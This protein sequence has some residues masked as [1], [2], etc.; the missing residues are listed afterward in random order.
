LPQLVTAIDPRVPFFNVGLLE[1]HTR[2]ATFQ[3]QLAANLLVVFGALALMLAAVGS[4]GVLSQLVAQ[5]RREIGIRLAVGASPASVFRLVARSGVRLVL[6]GAGVGFLL[7]LGVGRA[8]QTLLIGVRPID[9]LTYGVVFLLMA[10]VAV[11]SCVLPARRAA[12]I[13]PIAT[14]RED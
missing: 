13:D 4:Y 10:G 9:P 5:R 12:S 11:V 3:Q 7:S 8:L 6:V 2:A 14:L 1:A